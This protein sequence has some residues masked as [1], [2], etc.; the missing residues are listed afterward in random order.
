MTGLLLFLGLAILAGLWLHRLFEGEA[1]PLDLWD[2]WRLARTN[3]ADLDRRTAARRDRA[4]LIVSLTTIPSRLPFLGDTL[5]SLMRQT[6]PPAM[7]VLNLPY[8]SRREGVEYVLPDYL[9]GLSLVKINRCEDWGPATK[10]IPTLDLCAPG[11]RIVVVDDDRL[12]PPRFLADL[13][14]ASLVHPGS[15]LGFSGWVAPADLIDRPTTILSNLLMRPPA[16]VRATR[17]SLPYPVDVLQGMSGYLVRPEQLMDLTDYAGAPPAA[18]FVDDVWIGGHCRTSKLVV[19]SRRLGF[20]PWRRR[21]LYEIS[22]LGRI[23]RGDGGP[24]QR[25]NSIVLRFLA[26]RWINGRRPEGRG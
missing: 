18:F 5:A 11:Q 24:E 22:A 7:I 2:E 9:A 3:L 6:R 20:Q 17:L 21:G 14:A 15:M 16:P 13:E 25:H 26:D 4:D 23:N 19:P 10:L 8:R 12:Y 1:L